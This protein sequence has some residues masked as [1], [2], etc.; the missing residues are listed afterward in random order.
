MTAHG[1]RWL[2]LLAAMGTAGAP[3]V[4]TR[5]DIGGWMAQS[6]GKPVDERSM[7]TMLAQMARHGFLRKVNRTFY[8][9]TL[10][11]PAVSADEAAQRLR[12]GAVVSLQRVLGQ[13]GVLNNP[14]SWITAVVPTGQSA[15]TT[16]D[17]L[18][19]PVGQFHFFNMAPALLAAGAQVPAAD[20]LDPHAACPTAT[21]EKA[22]LDW[23]YL[24]TDARGGKTLAPPA[25]HD[26]D[27][28]LLDHERMD[29]LAAWMGLEAQWQSLQQGAV[30]ARRPR[31]R[32]G[33]I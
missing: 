3:R 7:S 18:R 4:F 5:S 13:N 19:T 9:N 15:G 2:R 16:A 32:R 10:A 30:P 31:R 27:L 33:L 29:R 12:S 26:L 23:L 6:L 14:T 28:D 11:V 22:L 1:P 17:G 24:S 21:A 25:A 8:I 20:I